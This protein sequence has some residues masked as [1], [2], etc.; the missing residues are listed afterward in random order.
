MFFNR[1]LFLNNSQRGAKSITARATTGFN[2]QDV[3]GAYR[4]IV[5]E[6]TK[7]TGL[8]YMVNT[9]PTAGFDRVVVGGIST[10]LGPNGIFPFTKDSVLMTTNPAGTAKTISFE[11]ET[12]SIT[13]TSGTTLF[14][15]QSANFT[16][17]YTLQPYVPYWIGFKALSGIG[18]FTLRDLTSAVQS[19]NLHGNLHARQSFIPDAG[20]GATITQ[21][22]IMALPYYT[23]PD[24]SQNE[25]FPK[26][27]VCDEDQSATYNLGSAGNIGKEF[28]VKFELND[29]YIQDWEVSSVI[30]DK[31]RVPG[32]DTELR[33]TIYEGTNFDVIVG[34]GMTLYGYDVGPTT[35]A[36]PLS[37]EWPFN[38]P[39]KLRTNKTYFAGIAWTTPITATTA[40]N[41]VIFGINNLTFNSNQ[42]SILS[43]RTTVG[44]GAL[45]TDSTLKPSISF[46]ISNT[47][48]VSRAIGN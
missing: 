22:F 8:S 48:P 11:V 10:S 33:L 14:T 32:P 26:Y 40:T 5:S 6:P 1:F 2:R 29:F 20:V 15:I 43:Y 35:V 46:Y 13:I 27:P 9:R 34:S 7:I 42:S 3:W 30:I 41:A 24:T 25:Y 47:F 44:T 38:P 16:S 28:G 12:N 23:N 18:T 21:D 36:Q 37:W 31:I 4:F 45:S 39:L 17:E 19:D